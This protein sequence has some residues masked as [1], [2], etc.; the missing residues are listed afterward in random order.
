[1]MV[2]GS[3]CGLY[4]GNGFVIPRNRTYIL[5]S[6]YFTGMEISDY[7]DAIDYCTIQTIPSHAIEEIL[8]RRYSI[9]TITSALR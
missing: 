1:M 6:I 8:A 5:S 9:G 4:G 3:Y 2:Y 7:G